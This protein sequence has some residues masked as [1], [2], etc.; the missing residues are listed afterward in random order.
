MSLLSS[1]AQEQP[2]RRIFIDAT[3]TLCSGRNSGIERVVR[4]LLRELEAI[5]DERLRDAFRL[6]VCSEGNFYPVEPDF[7]RRFQRLS[8]SRSDT[9]A[10]LPRIFRAIAKSSCQAVPSRRLRKWLLPSPGHVG[11]YKGWHSSV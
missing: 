1:I 4:S 6:V 11:V 5:D 7:R 8:Q 10:S 3:Y 2:T 9:V